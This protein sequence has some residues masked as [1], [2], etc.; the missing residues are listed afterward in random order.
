MG[1]WLFCFVLYF[2]EVGITGIS[3][4]RKRKNLESVQRLVELSR[5]GTVSIS[6]KGMAAGT[7]EGKNLG[8]LK[9][10]QHWFTSHYVVEREEAEVTSIP[11]FSCLSPV[12]EG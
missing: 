2:N 4:E 9:Q 10:R 8:N 12:K 7:K 6:I 1:F 5:K 11:R 3:G